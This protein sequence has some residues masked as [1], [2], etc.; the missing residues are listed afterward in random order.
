MPSRKAPGKRDKEAEVPAER[1]SVNR[2]RRSI[3]PPAALR[4]QDWRP[5]ARPAASTP[6]NNE[7]RC[8][9]GASL[10]MHRGW[11]P[12]MALIIP[13]QPL[14]NNGKARD[15]LGSL[16]PVLDLP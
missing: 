16:S 7:P 9:A 6:L 12:T 13:F 14:G 5:S 1:D 10:R 11:T 15:A 8:P 3:E 4:P 2:S